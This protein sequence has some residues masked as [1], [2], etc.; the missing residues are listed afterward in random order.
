MTVIKQLQDENDGKI[1]VKLLDDDT[2]KY[3]YHRDEKDPKTGISLPA[4]ELTNG[5][6]AWYINGKLHREDGPAIIN[7]HGHYSY[8]LNDEEAPWLATILKEKSLLNKSID[9]LK[10]NADK[11]KL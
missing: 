3:F 7:S 10:K 4:I 1:F 5:Y 11:F 8:Y 2:G 6:K 9:I